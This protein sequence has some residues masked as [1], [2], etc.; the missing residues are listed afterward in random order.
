MA[1]RKPGEEKREFHTAILFAD[2]F[3]VTYDRFSERGTTSKSWREYIL[4]FSAQ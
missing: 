1:A 4:Q 2:F 3:R